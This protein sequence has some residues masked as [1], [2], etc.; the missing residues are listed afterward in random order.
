MLRRVS[1]L[2]AVAALFVVALIPSTVSADT[3]A[4][5]IAIH[6]QAQLVASPPGSVAVTVDYSCLPG[7]FGAGIDVQV[8]QRSASNVAFASAICDDQKHSATIVVGPGPFSPGSA[9]ATA[10]VSNFGGSGASA[11]A[12]IMIK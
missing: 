8:S 4:A 10:G 2:I 5:T 12:E 11:T 1:R 7:P 3:P 6:S 9:A